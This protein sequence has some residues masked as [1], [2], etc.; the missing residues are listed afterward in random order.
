[1][2]VLTKKSVAGAWAF[3]AL[4]ALP[5][6]AGSETAGIEGTMRV[7]R[8]GELPSGYFAMASGY[9][10]GD[11]IAVTVESTNSSL[12]VLNV[13]SLEEDE[14]VTM[15]LSKEAAAVLGIAGTSSAKVKLSNRSGYFD[16]TA[17]GYCTVKG[18]FVLPSKALASPSVASDAAAESIAST[19]AQSAK[20]A[21]TEE[22]VSVVAAEEEKAPAP[23]VSPTPVVVMAPEPEK[24]VESELV[25]VEAPGPLEPTAIASAPKAASPA[26]EE[27]VP[28]EELVLLTPPESNSS[29]KNDPVYERVE[30][31]ELASA[32]STKS[33]PKAPVEELVLVEVPRTSTPAAAK[34]EPVAVFDEPSVVP[35]P[36]VKNAPKEELF[37][38]DVIAEADTKDE[39]EEI[40]EDF[41]EVVVIYD[42]ESEPLLAMANPSFEPVDSELPREE[43]PAE[44][45]VAAEVEEG[46][47]SP[48][49]LVPAT[50]SRP[51]V[52]SKPTGETRAAVPPAPV[53]AAA[54]PAPV[55]AAGVPE[56]ALEITPAPVATP[57]PAPVAASEEVKPPVAGV[58]AEAAARVV[59]DESALQKDCYYIQIAT[60][61]SQKNIDSTLQKYSKY[62]IVLVPAANPALHK[63]LV[64]PLSVDEYGAVLSKFKDAGYKDAFVKKR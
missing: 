9:L 7:A 16:E 17:L 6:V 30:V 54:A 51:P 55:A 23:V 15:L 33:A 56:P 46:A 25:L 40:E 42:D 2:K 8:E 59:A 3:A 53:A 32:G 12:Q 44:P 43:M 28:R 11:T 35:A 34:E 38:P 60:L 62:P 58:S 1:M 63:V 20:P 5:L 37:V 36:E 27:I 21:P 52:S 39:A 24:P 49:V 57:E 64:G 29:V 47:Y 22:R 18:S 19:P 48:I 4:L 26:K 13:G 31:E 61:A 45:A 14:G 50:S 41:S 10:P